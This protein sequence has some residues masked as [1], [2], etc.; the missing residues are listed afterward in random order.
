MDPRITFSQYDSSR[1]NFRQAWPRSFQELQIERSYLLNC[2]RREDHKATEF[3]G[4]ILLLQ[5]E[6]GHG[7]E[8]RGNKS[9]KRQLR[10]L[11]TRMRECVE[12]ENAIL[13]RLGHVTYNIQYRE[14]LIRIENERLYYI[15][16]YETQQM[17]RLQL[18]A[19]C[20]A[21]TP[22]IIYTQQAA[23]TDTVCVSS[24]TGYP[25]AVTIH[26]SASR[27]R[28]SNISWMRG[29][30][31]PARSSPVASRPR[32]A[33]TNNLTALVGKEKRLSMPEIRSCKID[34]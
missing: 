16:C 29:Q 14:K 17:Q 18:N 19:T 9:R 32:S 15:D 13:A 30:S 11:K 25:R 28:F 12:Q 4:N 10:Y 31:P 27:G 21:F 34:G 22:Q 33:S 7:A 23:T 8:L 1:G 5:D 6:F 3:L 24:Y 20:L 2:L 26:K